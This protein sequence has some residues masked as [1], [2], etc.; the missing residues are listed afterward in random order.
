MSGII[1]KVTIFD[2]F[3]FHEK[4]FFLKKNFSLKYGKEP[5]SGKLPIS[6]IILLHISKWLLISQIDGEKVAAIICF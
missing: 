2:D 4:K 5:F 1:K 3:F 6:K